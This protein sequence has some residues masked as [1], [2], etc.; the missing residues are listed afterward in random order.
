MVRF[1]FCD[2][3]IVQFTNLLFFFHTKIVFKNIFVNTLFQ[4]INLS[5]HD[6]FHM[7]FHNLSSKFMHYQHSNFKERL[8]RFN[9]L[10]L[11]INPSL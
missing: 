9:K 4:I 8:N 3:Y 1:L 5:C 7:F 10:F 6:A 11:S 2:N